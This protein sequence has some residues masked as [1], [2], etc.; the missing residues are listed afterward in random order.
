MSSFGPKKSHRSRDCLL[1]NHPNHMRPDYCKN[2]VPKPKPGRYVRGSVESIPPM[3]AIK[4]AVSPPVSFDPPS[5]ETSSND[6]NIGIS[7]MPQ[8]SGIAVQTFGPQDHLASV[9]ANLRRE[10]EAEKNHR[11]DVERQ[12]RA[13]RTLIEDAQSQHS[14]LRADLAAVKA[15]LENERRSMT[16]VDLNQ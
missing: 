8:P 2:E 4:P 16:I 3:K 7:P 13:A 1:N 6:I 15:E 11:E 10:L 5:R 12:L 9:A 14:S